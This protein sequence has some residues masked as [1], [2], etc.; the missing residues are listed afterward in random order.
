M[1]KKK[2][3]K[4]IEG[5]AAAPFWCLAALKRTMKHNKSECCES[6]SV[7]L[8]PDKKSCGNYHKENIPKH[9]RITI[10]EL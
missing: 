7:S 4:S 3:K 10:E 8:F 2:H 9:I 5:W 1:A 6:Y